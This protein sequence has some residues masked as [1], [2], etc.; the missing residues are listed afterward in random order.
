MPDFPFDELDVNLMPPGFQ[1][2]G[3]SCGEEELDDYITDGS[4]VRDMEASYSQT[5]L[6]THKGELVGYVSVLADAIHLQTKERPDGVTY[7]NAPALKL[8]RMAVRK[9][10]RG[11]HIGGWMLKYVVAVARQMATTCGCR[12]VTLDAKRREKLVRFYEEFGFVHNKGESSTRKIIRQGLS[13]IGLDVLLP[14]FSM[15]YDILLR[16][17]VSDRNSAG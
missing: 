15:R 11:N 6:V 7:P 2:G 16:Q 8:G 14:T 9:E 5:Y 4:A 1:P 3:F 13:R 10:Y 12:Y 17:E